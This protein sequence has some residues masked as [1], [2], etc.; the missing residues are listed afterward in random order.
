M[1]KPIVFLSHSSIDEKPLR[2]LKDILV[3]KT[4]GA[5]DLFLSSDGESIPLGYNWVHEVQQA[6][7]KSQLMFVF[8]SP[9]SIRSSW[10]HFESGYAYSKGIRVIPVGIL[11]IDLGQ[12]APPLSLLQGFNITA[13]SGLN[14]LIAVINHVF[15]HS[16]DE[17]FTLQEF[18]SVFQDRPSGKNLSIMARFGGIIDNIRITAENKTE[19]ELESLA[20]FLDSK[21]LEYNRR[22]NTITTYGMVA[23]LRQHHDRKTYLEITI[24]VELAK[25]TLPIIS[26]FMINHLGIS[27][28]VLSID[29]EFVNTVSLFQGQHNITARL[30]GTEVLLGVDDDLLQY[31]DII[32]K[33]DRHVLFTGTSTVQGNTHLTIYCKTEQ[34][35]SLN[36]EGLLDILFTQGVLWLEGAA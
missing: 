1:L 33:L 18:D 3:R 19:T 20:L 26:E 25:I 23:A 8:V 13:A 34:L 6:L 9:N 35:D 16:H 22:T 28:E 24:S 2:V 12:I 27:D 4:G 21:A 11:G 36:L 29:I 5:I 14:N 17:S 15:N 31:K 32:F 7:D 30:Y 10:I